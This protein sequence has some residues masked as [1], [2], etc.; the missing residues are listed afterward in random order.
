MNPQILDYVKSQKVGV[1][2]VEMLDGAPHAA[3]VHFAHSENPFMFFFETGNETRK[4]QPLFNKEKTRAS[5]VI[6]S[7]EK[8]MKTLQLDGEARL[9]R[10]DEKEL[11]DNI[12]FGKFPDKKEEGW[13]TDPE[14]VLFAFIPTWWRFTDWKTPEGKK[15]WVSE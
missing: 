11:F 10:D 4:A 14:T 8:N 3:A 6:G 13:D 9:I 2:A 1:L 15:I 7:D 12:Y 5:F